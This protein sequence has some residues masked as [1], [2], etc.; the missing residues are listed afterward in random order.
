[1]ATKKQL[2]KKKK[3]REAKAKARVLARRHK[4]D[5]LKK[6]ERRSAKL[7]NKFREK[8]APII[9]DPEAKRRF[10]EIENK[11]SIEKI[12]K[13]MQILKALEE[14]YLKEK[15][16]K[17]QLN[18]ELESEGHVTF[19]EKMKALEEK[20]RS[21]MTEQQA[22]TGTIVKSNIDEAENRNN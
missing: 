22:E 7:N 5:Q 4:L 9:K 3:A 13:N 15:E 10:E 19:Q 21:Q 16:L 14:E 6:E 1:M 11:K 2:E 18:E 17:K 20:A 8:I 12:E